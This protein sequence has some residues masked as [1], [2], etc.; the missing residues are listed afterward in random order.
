VTTSTIVALLIAFAKAVPAAAK[1]FDQI[2]D[3]WREHRRTQAHARIQDAVAAAQAAPW[4]CPAACPHRLQHDQPAA[5]P[6]RLAP[7]AS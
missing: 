5:E 2:G 6:D 7:S 1:L 3:A 4:E